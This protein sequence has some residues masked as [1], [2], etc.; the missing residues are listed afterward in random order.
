MG[1]R[2]R[3]RVVMV[4]VMIMIKT[5][6]STPLFTLPPGT[7]TKVQRQLG[8]WRCP[9]TMRHPCKPQCMQPTAHGVL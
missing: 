4:V 7:R 6:G 8:S 3:E 9:H 5:S 1:V 2:K